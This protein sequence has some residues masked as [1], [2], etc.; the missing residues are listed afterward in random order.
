MASQKLVASLGDLLEAEDYPSIVELC[1]EGAWRSWRPLCQP[2][3]LTAA[4]PVVQSSHLSRGTAMRSVP[5]ARPSSTRTGC[6][7][8]CTPRGAPSPSPSAAQLPEAISVAKDVEELAFE[9]A[10]ALYRSGTVRLRA[11][12]GAHVPPHLHRPPARGRPRRRGRHARPAV[13]RGTASEGP[14]GEALLAS[15]RALAGATPSADRV[16]AP[17]PAPLQLYKQHDFAASA[18]N[19]EQLLDSEE[20]M[21]PELRANVVAAMT[22]AGRASDALERLRE[23]GVRSAASHPTRGPVRHPPAHG[24]RRA[25][26]AGVLRARLQHSH[27]AALRGQERGRGGHAE[28]GRGCAQPRTPP[29]PLAAPPPPHAGALSGLGKSALGEEGMDGAEIADELAGVH[30]QLAYS[31]AAR[32]DAAGAS[33]LLANVLARKCVAPGRAQPAAVPP[34]P[35]PRPPW[36]TQAERQGGGRRCRQQHGGAAGRDRAVRLGQEVG[37]LQP[38]PALHCPTPHPP[39]ACARP[40]PRRIRSAMTHKDKLLPAQRSLLLASA[41][42]VSALMNK[43]RPPP[44]RSS[45]VLL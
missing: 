12:R 18:E 13:L 15:G 39:R 4:I 9:H 2:P 8:G 25:G 6:V 20:P 24:L 37:G 26:P 30:V 43:A 33:A 7:R 5:S 17:F 28:A 27:C 14:A 16:F 1:D 31:V 3:T 29:P 34:W 22:A 35:Y 23:L 44:S 42:S 38:S 11:R 21:V 41:A 32:G 45:P 36:L 10:Y 19:Y 40:P